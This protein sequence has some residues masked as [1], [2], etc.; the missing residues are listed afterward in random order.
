MADDL[1]ERLG[2]DVKIVPPNDPSDP[3]L[4]RDLGL[5]GDHYRYIDE[6]GIGWQ[7]PQVG[8]PLLRPLPPPLRRRRHG[9]GG[10]SLSLA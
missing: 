7:M 9:R 3:G 6:F 5:V 1:I 2:V 10:R 8:R 4:E